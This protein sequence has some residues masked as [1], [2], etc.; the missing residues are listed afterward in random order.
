M[1]TFTNGF[2]K[3][4]WLFVVVLFVLLQAVNSAQAQ[5]TS[6]SGTVT[7]ELGERL[8]GVNV[9]LKGTNTGVTTDTDGRYVITVTGNGTL[10][11]TFVGY[12]P[13]EEVI[14]NRSTIDVT[15]MPDITTLGE[16][17]VIGYGT[18][19]RETVT[20]SISTIK[21]EDFNAGLINDP[22]TLIS[23]KVAG[24]SVSHPNRSDPNATADFS[25]R[26]PATVEGNSQP[27]IIIDGVPGGNLQTIAPADIASIDVLK[28]GSAAAIYG[29]RATAGVIIITTKKGTAGITRLNYNGNITTDIVARKY[30]VLNA[31]QYR[32]V[33]DE[34]GF[35]PDD[36]G[37][38]TDWFDEVTRTPVSHSHNVS[39]SGGSDK[40]T[41]YASLNYRNFQ[42]MD[43]ASER[44]FVN[45]T[46][47]V[48]TKALNDKLDFSLMLTN[49]Y[50]TRD[51]AN[52]GAIAQTLNMNPTFPVRN[53]DGSFYERP[54]IQFG[55]MWNPVASMKL[56]SSQN[57]EKRLLSTFN[58][59]YQI[60]P[61]LKAN[62]TYSLI[63]NDFFNGSYSSRD[64]FFQQRNGVGGQASR[65]VNQS[66]NNIV[67][68][69]LSYNKAFNDHNFDII[70]G[71][72]Y[73][74]IF[75]EGLSAGNNNFNTDAFRFY[76]LGAGSALNNLSPNFNRSGVFVGSYADERT[77]MAFF[78][79]VIYDYQDR[80][81]LNLSVR[82][83]GAS[84][85]GRDNKWG[86]FT[87]VSAGWVLTKENF[88]QNLA[89][90]K[91]LKLRAGY[92]VTGNQ[93]SLS[94]YQS[95]AT[96]AP[97]FGGTQNG[98]FGVPGDGRWILP[99]G[100]TINP[101]PRLQW[102][103]KKEVN[104]GLDFALL[105][106]GWLSGSIDY[107]NRRIEDLVGNYGAQLPS[108]IHPNIFAN[109]GLM[110]NKGIELLLNAQVIKNENFSW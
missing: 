1:E 16:V 37:A 87:G 49:T 65:D 94:P 56:N 72:S 57:K 39:F 29:S 104:V 105:E 74:N 106:N 36:G 81:L 110:E 64:D 67:E 61:S 89:V 24:L 48:N 34:Y 55:L 4:R 8:P 84:V 15:L 18:Q 62:V 33:A 38:D 88:L 30:D 101:N 51:F 53:P 3:T 26:G 27:L 66:T 28:D 77:L 90:V 85:F 102:E 52:Y 82:R 42:G 96:I 45:G 92:G 10:V 6:I 19:T 13:R 75:T 109:A 73:Q 63:K 44:E 68:T 79:R 80:Y 21:A 5:H 98:F 59:G 108:Q 76:N 31:D 14:N 9:V 60:L 41:Y 40:T 83:E 35:T 86:T 17:V 50:D 69:I 103:T 100:P 97:F 93:E 20:G 91:N 46:F 107:Y 23:G 54:D 95:L 22:M 99:Y 43:L 11:F 2:L 71:Y 58:V 70:A 12:E 47:R 78:G 32:Q 25:L 7:D